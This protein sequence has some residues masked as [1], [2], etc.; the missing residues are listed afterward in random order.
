M[1]R[2]LTVKIETPMVSV[3]KEIYLNL[4]TLAAHEQELVAFGVSMQCEYE[5]EVGSEKECVRERGGGGGRARSATSSH[6]L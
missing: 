3:L 5:V 4:E 6:C 2:E 1:R